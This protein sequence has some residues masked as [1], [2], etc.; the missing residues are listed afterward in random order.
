[1]EIKGEQIGILLIAQLWSLYIYQ[2]TP[3][4]LEKRPARV[5]TCKSTFRTQLASPTFSSYPFST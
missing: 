2:S 3:R 4:G 5:R 1:M